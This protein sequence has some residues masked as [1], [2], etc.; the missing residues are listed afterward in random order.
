M[1][2]IA[3]L[4]RPWRYAALI[5]IAVVVPGGIALAAGLYYAS[6]TKV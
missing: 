3:R 5:A 4:P 2:R 1:S 6:K